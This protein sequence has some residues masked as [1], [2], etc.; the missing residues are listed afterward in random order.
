GGELV[1][2]GRADAQ[3]K[4]RGFRIEPG[5]VET[6]LTALPGISAGAVV[7][8]E[9]RPGDRRLVGYAVFTDGAAPDVQERGGIGLRSALS[10]VL[11]EH[12]VPSAVVVLERLPLT[13]NGKL[14]RRALPEPDFGALSRG[15][16]PR[17]ERE[18]ELCALFAELLGLE[19]VTVDDSFFDLGGHSLLAARLTT[20]IRASHGVDITLK[21]LFRAPTVAEL[22]HKVSQATP[23]RRSRPKLSRRTRAGARL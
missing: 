9:D 5:E 14:D 1:V 23:A 19:S 3:V 18:E 20:R 17:D 8:R 16:A 10:E 6:A 12:M 4:V 22:A 11:P 2:V 7:V 13:A 21:D 15:R